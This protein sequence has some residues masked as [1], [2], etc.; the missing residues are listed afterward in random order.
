MKSADRL[1]GPGPP[2]ASKKVLDW[3][4]EDDQPAVQYLTLK[5][6]AAKAEDDPEVQRAKEL[7]PK[8]GWAADVLARQNR[9]GWWLGPESRYEP[10]YLS[11][12]WMLL[13]LSELALAMGD[14]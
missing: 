5:E 2:L 10:K 11:R 4:L 13:V 7:M 12:N 3:L 6:L 8:N 1:L 9:D 14:L